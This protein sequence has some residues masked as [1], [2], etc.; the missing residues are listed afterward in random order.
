MERW[1]YKPEVEGLSP[2]SGTRKRE[3]ETGGQGDGAGAWL[4]FFG[5]NYHWVLKMF[6]EEIRKPILQSEQ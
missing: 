2:S 3:G 4:A 6:H 1:S 5:K